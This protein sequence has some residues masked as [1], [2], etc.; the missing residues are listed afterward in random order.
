VCSKDHAI[1]PSF[2]EGV[3]GSL[4]RGCVVTGVSGQDGVAAGC[5]PMHDGLK[6]RG[7][8]RE[9]PDGDSDS[10]RPGAAAG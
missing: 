7:E 9:F 5:S 2:K 3:D 8:V 4:L 6:D 10:D 1:N